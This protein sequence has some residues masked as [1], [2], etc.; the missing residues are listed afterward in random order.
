MFD[1]EEEDD[2][3]IQ[4]RLPRQICQ[5]AVLV[6]R[7]VDYWL[8]NLPDMSD[9][10]TIRHTDLKFWSRQ[11]SKDTTKGHRYLKG[12]KASW[13]NASVDFVLSMNMWPVVFEDQEGNTVDL[14]DEVVLT[15][16]VSYLRHMVRARKSFLIAHIILIHALLTNDSTTSKTTPSGGRTKYDSTTSNTTP[17]GGRTMALTTSNTTPSGEPPVFFQHHHSG[18]DLFSY[19]M[20]ILYKPHIT[21]YKLHVL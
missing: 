3:K 8:E 4:D 2:I 20:R 12:L 1:T 6:S 16:W 19:T 11:K 15:F 14:T 7:H 9:M 18:G 10:P 21:S 5:S 17:S 13:V